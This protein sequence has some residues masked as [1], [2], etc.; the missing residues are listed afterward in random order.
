MDRGAMSGGKAI[1]LVENN[2]LIKETLSLILRK[3]GYTVLPVDSLNQ[4]CQYLS[5]QAC[6]LVLIDIPDP[7]A[8]ELD[9]IAEIRSSSLDLPILLLTAHN[10]SNPAPFAGNEH[11]LGY[12]VKPVDPVHI[13]EL[14]EQLIGDDC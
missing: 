4:G 8:N 12:L 5:G 14:I 2:L 1:L 10:P 7:I 11:N 6:D 9:T 13:L 3:V